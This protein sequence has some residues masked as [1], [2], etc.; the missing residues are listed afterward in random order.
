MVEPKHSMTL[1][2]TQPLVL[3]L[4][5]TVTINDCANATLAIGGRPLMS[6]NSEE[7][8]ELVQISS[9]V[10]LNIGTMEQHAIPLFLQL[11]KI[12]NAHKKAVILD[13]VGVGASLARTQ[14]VSTLLQHGRISVIKGNASEIAALYGLSGLSKG[15]DS[16]LA[17]AEVHH[18][19]EKLA[20]NYS[21]VVVVTG[22][23]DY[24]TDGANHQ[25]LPLGVPQLADVCGTGC[26]TASLIASF[27]GLPTLTPFEAAI[28]GVSAMGIAGEL[29]EKE[30]SK[31]LGH[32][33]AG[34][35]DALYTLDD[36]TYSDYFKRVKNIE[37][38]N[39][40]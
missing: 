31:K 20:Q 1:R 38:I 13:P 27:A 25:I 6:F 10:V 23:E 12:A 36:Q 22:K 24:I 34:L 37:K 30:H 9:S 16:L 28:F 19:A 14:L 32:F 4:T 8:N 2:T 18:F 39:A 7:Y 15:V 3:H 33:K 35:F 40:L 21:S 17:V 5:N 29:S 11:L 26:M